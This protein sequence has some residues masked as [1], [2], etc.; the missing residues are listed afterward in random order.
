[1]LPKPKKHMRPRELLDAEGCDGCKGFQVSIA[2]F[3]PRRAAEKA[4]G[5]VV[6]SRSAAD[7]CTTTSYQVSGIISVCLQAY[8]SSTSSEGSVTSF[9]PVTR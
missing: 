6:D 2:A 4:F 7:C 3:L 9:I 5:Y 8:A 1:M